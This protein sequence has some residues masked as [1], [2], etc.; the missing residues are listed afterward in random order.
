M[1]N[2]DWNDLNFF[3]STALQGSLTAAAKE[4]KVNHTTVSRRI[5]ALE[6]QLGTP[7]FERSSSGLLITPLGQSLIPYARQIRDSVNAV[8]RMVTAEQQELAGTLRI[9][10]MDL[11]GPRLAVLVR[12]FCSQYP[13]IDIE[14]ILKDEHVN[15]SARE[16]D[17]ALRATNN[18]AP[19]VVGKCM[20]RFA[21]ALYGTAEVLQAYQRDPSSVSAI[22]W[23]DDSPNAPDWAH[24]HLPGLVVRHRCSSMN[25]V[26]A[27]TK[28]GCGIARL[29]CGLGDTAAELQ[30]L[31][32]A[33]LMEGMGL[34]V[35]SHID[36][37]NNSRIRTFRDFLLTAL[38]KTMPLM[39]GKCENY[40]RQNL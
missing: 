39:E 13:Q 23:H 26:Y 31:P 33:P 40:W 14:L 35:L 25:G 17:I 27:M 21:L 24:E 29:P 15:L 37:R 22:G 10:A 9:T 28:A 5:S 16:A 6:Q 11:F 8:D 2:I 1:N 7:L 32:D 3:L 34:W 18:P 12:E 36:L 19:D 4:L 38:E 30:R 20:G